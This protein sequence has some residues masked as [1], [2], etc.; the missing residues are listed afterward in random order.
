MFPLSLSE[1]SFTIYIR[2]CLTGF[3]QIAISIKDAVG[4]RHSVRVRSGWKVMPR[5][6]PMHTRQDREQFLYEQVFNSVYL[7]DI[8]HSA[9]SSPRVLASKDHINS[10]SF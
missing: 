1:W 2:H 4:L 5:R 7:W 3:N 10:F 8:T 6:K 9:E